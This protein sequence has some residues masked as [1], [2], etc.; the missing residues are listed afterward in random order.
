M[1][2]FLNLILIGMYF[3]VTILISVGLY[4]SCWR[5]VG[6][7]ESPAFKSMNHWEKSLGLSVAVVVLFSFW[8]F[9]IWGC[10]IVVSGVIQRIS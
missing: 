7:I 4:I 9:T 8:F 6:Y 2:L 3:L 5:L 1:Q 10:L